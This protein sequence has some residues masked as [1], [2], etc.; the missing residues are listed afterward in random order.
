MS[1]SRP[2]I[3]SY[4]ETEHPTFEDFYHENGQIYWYASDFVRWLGYR[5]YAPTMVP[6]NKAMSVC[7]SIPTIITAHHFREEVRYLNGS[8]VKDFKLSRFACYLVSMN[9]DSRKAQVAK[10]Q[11]YFAVLVNSIQEFIK[12]HEDIERVTLRKDISEREKTLS[13]TASQAG[14]ERYAYFANKG[15]MGLYN[16][17]I[18]K[19]RT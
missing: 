4:F 5:E 10:A 18:N 7:L 6:I 14:V 13:S 9:A 16:M 11:A 3:D 15:Y 19:L 8:L 1:E 12:S 17:P 2:D